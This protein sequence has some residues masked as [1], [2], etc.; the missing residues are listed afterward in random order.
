MSVRVS[1]GGTAAVRIASEGHSA[2][3]GI[4]SPPI[5]VHCSGEKLRRSAGA[6]AVCAK[7]TAVPDMDL[8]AFWAG[9]G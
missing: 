1:S 3:S 8:R 6:R 7:K 2:H 9:S 4:A 5:A